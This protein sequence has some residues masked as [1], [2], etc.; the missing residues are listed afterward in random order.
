M[1]LEMVQKFIV[2]KIVP[3]NYLRWRKRRAF[4]LARNKKFIE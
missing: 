4:V 2:Q 3:D 1:K